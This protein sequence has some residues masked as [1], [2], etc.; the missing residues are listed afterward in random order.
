VSESPDNNFLIQV[1]LTVAA[2]FLGAFASYLFNQR[3]ARR[4]RKAKLNSLAIST[5]RK[6]SNAHSASQAF[7]Q[8]F[9]YKITPSTNKADYWAL[10]KTTPHLEQSTSEL[11]DDEFEFLLQSDDD[12]KLAHMFSELINAVKINTSTLNEY[13]NYK[14]TLNSMLAQQP[15]LINQQNGLVN[16]QT[17]RASHPEIA[18]KIYEVNDICNQAYLNNKAAIDLGN[19][20][21]DKLNSA[22]PLL[23]ENL[24][25]SKRIVQDL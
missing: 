22:L 24:K 20:V 23:T 18:I 3:E 4:T 8:S 12:G 5:L 1:L 15:G 16:T 25:F 6:I 14:Q 9:F 19:I 7:D 21:V 10:V 17:I 11:S 13:A 2:A